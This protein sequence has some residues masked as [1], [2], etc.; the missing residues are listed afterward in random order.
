MIEN[1]KLDM[2]LVELGVAELTC[3][4]L[5]KMGIITP[6]QIKKAGVGQIMAGGIHGAKLEALI[7]VLEQHNINT[8]RLLFASNPYHEKAINMPLTSAIKDKQVLKELFKNKVYKVK[9]LFICGEQTLVNIFYN[10]GF[11]DPYQLVDN[12]WEN[13]TRKIGVSQNK[14]GD[15]VYFV[16]STTVVDDFRPE[17]SLIMDL[18]DIPS[19]IKNVLANYGVFT[20]NDLRNVNFDAVLGISRSEYRAKLQELREKYFGGVSEK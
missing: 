4:K 1:E 19:K 3:K 16:S 15:P 12:V 9:H 20:I 11:E 10:A 14:N 18:K 2:N 5:S 8:D 13:V 7:S 17:D 6:N